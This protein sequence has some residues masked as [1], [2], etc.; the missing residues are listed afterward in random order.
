MKPERSRWVVGVVLLV[1]VFL[2]LW[3]C[4]SAED[5]GSGELTIWDGG[6][7]E[8]EEDQSETEEGQTE[9]DGEQ[10]ETDGEQS[11]ADE[12]SDEDETGEGDSNVD[13]VEGTISVYVCGAVVSEGVYELEDGSRIYEALEAAGGVTEEAM[14]SYLNLAEALA[15]GQKVYVPTVVEVEEGY[16]QASVSTSSG[17]ST[18]SD[19]GTDGTG[20]V[21]INTASLDVLMTLSGIGESKAQAIIDYRTSQG[22]FQAPED[23]LNVTGIKEGVYSAIADDIEV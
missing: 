14:E 18:T 11:E 10:S 3:G 4:G 6:Q 7:T 19:G 8:T 2:H 20:K 22:E 13:S 12:E 5:E 16:S 9:T 15:D 23:I 17:T 1:Y 21:N